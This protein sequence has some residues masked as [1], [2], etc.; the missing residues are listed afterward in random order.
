MN[1]YYPNC[2]A[3]TYEDVDKLNAI[4]EKKQWGF[5]FADCLRFIADHMDASADRSKVEN[6]KTLESIEYMLTDCNF[7]TF[8]KLL[9]NEEYVKALEWVRKEY[10]EE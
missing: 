4:I 8:C 10:T 9:Y 2:E 5:S 7:H 6:I 1:N 3:L